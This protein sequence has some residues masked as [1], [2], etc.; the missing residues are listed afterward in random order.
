MGLGSL[1]GG[2]GYGYGYGY[3]MAIAMGL[4]FVIAIAGGIVLHFTF[5]SPKNENKFTGFLGWIYEFFNFRKLLI[6]TILRITYLI[7]TI[8]MVFV[9][10]ITLFSSFFGGVLVLLG[11]LIGTRIIYE[12]SLLFILLCRNVSDIS[13]KL[14]AESEPSKPAP[15]AEPVQPIVQQP[16]ASVQPVAPVQT[17]VAEPVVEAIPVTPNNACPACGAQCADDARFCMSCGTARK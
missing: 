1:L 2:Y 13:K 3:G 7:A 15:I 9:G 10:F 5:L 8:Y 14:G 16:V 11:G 12:V 4:T 6:E 17:P